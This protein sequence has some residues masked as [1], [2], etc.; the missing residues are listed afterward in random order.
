MKRKSLRQPPTP[1]S[2]IFHLFCLFYDEF[3][4]IGTLFP[5]F[6][7]RKQNIL[8]NQIK[9]C[10]T[11]EPRDSCQLIIVS[12]NCF[13]LSL[14]IWEFFFWC[15]FFSWFFRETFLLR[16]SRKIHCVVSYGAYIIIVTSRTLEIFQLVQN[17]RE[18]Q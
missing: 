6:I 7:I 13:E 10:R 18:S 3:F 5:I 11:V 16:N 17:S 2:L 8:K 14:F 15:L 9:T 1:P 12:W 4:V